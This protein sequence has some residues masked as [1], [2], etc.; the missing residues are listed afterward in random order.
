MAHT[1][2]P[3]VRLLFDIQHQQLIRRISNQV[4][5]CEVVVASSNVEEW[6]VHHTTCSSQS[7]LRLVLEATLIVRKIVYIQNEVYGVFWG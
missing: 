5:E 4:D 1:D 2:N 6:N 7:A 3:G